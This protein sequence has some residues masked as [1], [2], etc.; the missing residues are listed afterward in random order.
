MFV[1]LSIPDT[2]RSVLQQAMHHYEDHLD[3]FV[4]EQNWHITLA[5][6]GSDALSHSI[7]PELLKPLPQSF[8]MTVNITHVGRGKKPD[9][10][11]AYAAP[12]VALQKLHQATIERLQAMHVPLPQKDSLFI[13]HI[14]LGYLS[15]A[16]KNR[17][18][19][20]QAS[21]VTFPVHQLDVYES[22]A[23]LAGQRYT[24][25]GQIHLK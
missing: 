9:M 6:L 3:R 22:A 12:T 2:A 20:D 19:A 13:P 17:G 5:W 10:L 21:N 25:I 18:L 15:E 23:T 4:P 24:S 7:L 14:S 1:A 16:L 11:W 8:T